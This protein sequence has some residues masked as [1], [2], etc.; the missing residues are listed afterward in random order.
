M[1]EG[2]TSECVCACKRKG[3]LK[4]LLLLLLLLRKGIECQFL[5]EIYTSD[6]DQFSP[7]PLFCRPVYLLINIK[8]SF[9]AFIHG[10]A[11]SDHRD[12]LDIADTKTHVESL[13]TFHSIDIFDGFTEAD[14]HLWV[15]QTTH[16][17]ST[18]DDLIA[19][20]VS[21]TRIDIIKQ[22]A[23]SYL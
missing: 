1:G 10:K 16:L 7:R 9:H 20:Y 22:I 5:R 17:H 14:K 15:Q 8:H 3:R 18:S 23:F 6:L 21:H 2:K 13:E 12:D 19:T 4:E 11:D